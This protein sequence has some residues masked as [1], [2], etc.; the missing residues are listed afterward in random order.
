M[1]LQI[2]Y[3]I[4]SYFSYRNVAFGGIETWASSGEEGGGA[5]EWRQ[6]GAVA[7]DHVAAPCWDLPSFHSATSYDVTRLSLTVCITPP[8]R[9]ASLQAK[10]LG[11]AVFTG[12]TKRLLRNA[13]SPNLL[14][15]PPTATMA[16]YEYDDYYDSDD[17]TLV[18]SPPHSNRRRRRRAPSVSEDSY[19]SR[20]RFG[21]HTSSA[22]DGFTR[23]GEAKESS[24]ASKFGKVAL[25]AIFVTVV[26]NAFNTWM[27]KK[28]EERDKDR[29][30]EKRRQ[31]EKAKARRRREED[32]RE[33]QRE[34]RQRRAEAEYEVTEIS[35][36]RRIGYAPAEEQERSRSRQPRRLEA[37]PEQE[38][39][40]EEQDFSERRRK[41]RSR[42]RPAVDVT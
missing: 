32:R 12:T 27:K 23:R 42:S 10:N 20:P 38:G 11:K 35:E 19:T 6:I 8:H 37:P 3:T 2:Q 5:S 33:R 16:R 15:L 25:G 29:L 24:T 17:S 22:S 36:V 39:D 4:Q 34:E 7:K 14:L 30:R 13:L 9:S 18:N 26:A 40:D 31:F 1:L 41:N 21:R 28:E